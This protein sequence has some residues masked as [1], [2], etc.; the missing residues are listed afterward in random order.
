MKL[1]LDS[2]NIEEIK[3]ANE[4]GI[5]CGVTTNPSIIAKEGKDFTKPQIQD[6]A[7][8]QWQVA[9]LYPRSGERKKTYQPIYARG[10]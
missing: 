2:A 7:G 4:F 9:H 6:L 10:C 3:R 5:I 1:F 8:E